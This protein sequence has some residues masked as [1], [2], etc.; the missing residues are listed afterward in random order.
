MTLKAVRRG[1]SVAR[2]GVGAFIRPCKRITFRYCNGGGSSTGLKHF[3]NKRLQQF[4]QENKGIELVVT[5]KQGH[6]VI[7][8]EYLSGRTKPICVKNLTEAEIAKRVNYLTN[9]SGDKLKKLNN[10]VKSLNQSVRGVWSPFHVLPQF[11]YKV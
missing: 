5:A 6:P 1:V 11:R 2:N 9:S 4:S 10:Q 8:A 7:T 3:L